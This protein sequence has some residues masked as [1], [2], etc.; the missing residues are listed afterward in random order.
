MTILRT[1][2]G[3]RRL[4]PVEWERLQGFPDGWTEGVPDTQ[5]FK[6]CGDAVTV[7]VAVKPAT[8]LLAHLAKERGLGIFA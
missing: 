4:T 1:P 6:L 7:P 2:D 8:R 5:R 3:D